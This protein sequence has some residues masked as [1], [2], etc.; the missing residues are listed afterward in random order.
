MCP[1]VD[2]DVIEYAARTMSGHCNRKNERHRGKSANNKHLFQDSEMMAASSATKRN[3]VNVDNEQCFTCE[4]P[5][6][7]YKKV[8]KGHPW[9]S[10]Y[11]RDRNSILEDFVN[12]NVVPRFLPL[13]ATNRA[14]CKNRFCILMPIAVCS[15]KRASTKRNNS[16]MREDKHTSP[17]GYVEVQTTMDGA[18][19]M[20]DLKEQYLNFRPRHLRKTVLLRAR[21]Y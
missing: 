3:Y 15:R 16:I 9:T 6:H 7:R 10:I 8:K 14:A 1:G 2:L 5:R 13:R 12:S 19:K 18:A 20:Y 21:H 4:K 11:N 17:A